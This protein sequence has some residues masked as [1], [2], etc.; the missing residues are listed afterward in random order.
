[1][2]KDESEELKGKSKMKRKL[3]FISPFERYKRVQPMVAAEEKR[4]REKQEKEEAERLKKLQKNQED[5]TA[6]ISRVHEHFKKVV[7]ENQEPIFESTNENQ[8]REIASNELPSTN[9]NRRGSQRNPKIVTSF[10][11]SLQTLSKMPGKKRKRQLSPE[12]IRPNKNSRKKSFIDNENS[13]K[14]H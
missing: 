5:I 9:L 3:V 2:F 6:S 7:Q 1:M 10:S 12:T 14:R 11:P 8:S 4:E 13:R